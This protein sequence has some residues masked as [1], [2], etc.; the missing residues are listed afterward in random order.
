M[1]A[2]PRTDGGRHALAKG[3]PPAPLGAS[4]LQESAPSR[5]L[6]RRTVLQD[7][8]PA[9]RRLRLRSASNPILPESAPC[10]GADSWATDSCLPIAIPSARLAACRSSWASSRPR[11]D[12]NRAHAGVR[13]RGLRGAVVVRI[14]VDVV[15]VG[16]AVAVDDE[17]DAGDVNSVGVQEAGVRP[18]E[19]VTEVVEDAEQPVFA[20]I[21]GVPGG[22]ERVVDAA[23][24]GGAELEPLARV[25]PHG[26]QEVAP[27]ELHARDARL[28]RVDVALEE[29]DAVDG[30]LEVVAP[31]VAREG[32]RVVETPDAEAL[33]GAVVLGDERRRGSGGLPRRGRPARSWP[34]SPGCGCRTP[35]APRTARPC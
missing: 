18:E 32:L 21:S 15:G 19:R 10:Y 23:G 30:R 28:G 35:R 29:R 3:R 9:V 14:G 7:S 2:S 4:I 33:A 16:D 8:G 31:G 13:R 22:A 1:H 6:R 5:S 17:L 26:V 20:A 24:V 25:D 27:D 11:W 34:P 12:A